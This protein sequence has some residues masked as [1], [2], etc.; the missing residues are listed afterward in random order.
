MGGG[1]LARWGGGN[2]VSGRCAGAEQESAT[3]GRVWR[4]ESQDT[5]GR[6]LI[7]GSQGDQRATRPGAR[8][9]PC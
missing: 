2:A 6:A 1:V 4:S 9:S 3:P 8:T 5:G 7:P